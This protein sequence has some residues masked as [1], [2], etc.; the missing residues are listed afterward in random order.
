MK[1]LYFIIS[2]FTIV[3]LSFAQC[4]YDIGD[5]NQDGTLDIIDIVEMVDFV[6]EMDSLCFENG[7]IL[8]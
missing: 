3:N 7:S 4:N 8:A 2:I 1:L 5:I 6:P